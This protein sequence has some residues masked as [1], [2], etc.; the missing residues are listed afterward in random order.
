M[1]ESIIMKWVD[2][3]NECEIDAN[4]FGG[5]SRTSTTYVFVKIVHLWYKSTDTLDSYV[6][7]L[8]LYFSKTCNLVNH[9]LLLEKL[10]MYGLP[11]HCKMDGNV[12]IGHKYIQRIYI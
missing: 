7:V 3:A 1:F 10:K 8:M 11:S 5:I 4:Q 12:S 9:H 6:R 2:Q